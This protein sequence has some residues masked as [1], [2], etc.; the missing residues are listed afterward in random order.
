M[1]EVPLE[2]LP[3]VRGK[4]QAPHVEDLGVG[5]G[6]GVC[7]HITDKLVH[8]VLRFSAR[9]PDED[10]VAAVDRR[11][12]R[13]L[14]GARTSR[15]APRVSQSGWS[16]PWLRWLSPSPIEATAPGSWIAG[17]GVSG[18]DVGGMDGAIVRRGRLACNPPLLRDSTENRRGRPGRGLGVKGPPREAPLRADAS[19]GPR[20]ADGAGRLGR[21]GVG[22]G[23]GDG[24]RVL[25]YE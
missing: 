25:V 7:L 20:V 12:E 17:K 8:E 13:P 2:L 22:T 24:R 23:V 19:R 1:A 3:Q 5:D 10:A 21:G 18:R 16:I 14:G 4:P 9:G 15:D 6:L 11:G